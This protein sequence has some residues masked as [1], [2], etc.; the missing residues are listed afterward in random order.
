MRN[1][2]AIDERSSCMTFC[3]VLMIVDHTVFFGLVGL[4]ICI[5]ACPVDNSDLRKILVWSLFWT[6]PLSVASCAARCVARPSRLP[7]HLVGLALLLHQ[8][9]AALYVILRMTWGSPHLFHAQIVEGLL[10][11]ITLCA[12]MILFMSIYF[13]EIIEASPAKCPRCAA[14]RP[15]QV[16][17]CVTEAEL[18][19]LQHSKTC[20]ICLE[21]HAVGDTLGR[22]QCG[23]LFHAT[24]LGTWIDNHGT[25]RLCPFRCPLIC[26][27][28]MN[29]TDVAASVA[30]RAPLPV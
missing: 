19:S 29:I 20:P 30:S 12:D 13:Q 17:P 27:N 6:L 21:E 26:G 8:I 5:A 14:H 23:H 3:N 11:G 15:F 22:L 28:G 18:A 2:V 16:L 24:C 4:T 10:L 1:G 7:R 25:A 9:H